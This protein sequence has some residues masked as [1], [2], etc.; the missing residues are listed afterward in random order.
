MAVVGTSL[1]RSISVTL[2]RLLIVL[3]IVLLP[4]AAHG[5]WDLYEARQLGRLV[6]EMAARHEP[7]TL[8]YLRYPLATAE[9]RRSAR[10][11]ASAADLAVARLQ[12][13]STWRVDGQLDRALR[14]GR[15]DAILADIQTRLLEDEPAFDL[16]RRANAL[17]FAG[18]G[19]VA[20]SLVEL[21]WPLEEL[22]RLNAVKA[23]VLALR[24]DPRAA[25]DALVANIR[26]LRTFAG[27]FYRRGAMRQSY[28]SLRLLLRR[29]PPDSDTLLRLQ[30]AYEALP[31]EDDI[32]MQLETQ[33]A[34]LLGQF[35]PYPP[36]APGWAFRGR[37]EMRGHPDS[38]AFV[39][40]R[41][42]L[43]RFVREQVRVFDGA[44]AIARQ[45]WPRKLDEADAFARQHGTGRPRPGRQPL[46]QRYTGFWVPSGIGAGLLQ[47]Y[48]QA[49]GSDL[50]FRRTA[51]VALAA[52]RARRDHA[53]Q[54]PPTLDA[55][56]P[57]YLTRVP[58][59]PFSGQPL[60]YR[61]EGGAYTIYSVDDDRRDDGGALYGFASGVPLES[62]PSRLHGPHDL[63][64]R[65][66]LTPR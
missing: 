16:L 19:P 34:F 51:V 13:W 4:I 30:H 41:P 15:T 10:L 60:R 9:Q 44:I 35:W 12:E 46:I 66:E 49:A 58:V 6:A 59:D 17:D 8:D 53:G 55:L 7:T 52:E 54:P 61:I 37:G 39:L 29:A 48:L 65:I 27:E 21:G 32:A 28:D 22:N 50:A 25:A 14:D 43:T 56:V 11:Y 45:P 63:G 18:F 24:G 3:M 62:T 36:G 31:D 20:P 5:I 64:I 33:R 47:S 23:D 38:L 42:L 57:A 2:R 1:A 26:L 40:A